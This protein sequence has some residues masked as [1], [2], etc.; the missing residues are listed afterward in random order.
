MNLTDLI[1]DIDPARLYSISG[2]MECLK[3]SEHTVRQYIESGQ[4]KARRGR[5][6]AHPKIPGAA[7]IKFIEGE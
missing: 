4:L 2:V 3:V 5:P 6:G 1:A 7:L